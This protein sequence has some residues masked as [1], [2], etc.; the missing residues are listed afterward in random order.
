MRLHLWQATIALCV[1]AVGVTVTLQKTSGNLRHAPSNV[2]TP[3]GD[4]AVPVSRNTRGRHESLL[5]HLSS[6]DGTAPQKALGPSLLPGG[7]GGKRAD[8]RNPNLPVV[9]DGSRNVI[10]GTVVH[11]SNTIAAVTS[12]MDSNT[13]QGSD[14][15]NANSG[16]DANARELAR[17]R[18]LRRAIEEELRWP[19]Q[20]RLV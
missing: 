16:E 14:V 6:I 10:D 2:A 19:L 11:S 18:C 15:S 12:D 17:R 20:S 13:A 4:V 3:A 5:N 1:A 9:D 7:S 8:G